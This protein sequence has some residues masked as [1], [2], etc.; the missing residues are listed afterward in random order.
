MPF[1]V[2]SLPERLIF[3]TTLR[4]MRVLYILLRRHL[5]IIAAECEVALS[6]LIQLL[7]PD[8]APPWKRVLCMEV[9]RGVYAEP[10]LIRKIF[11]SFDEQDG[12]KNILKDHV[13]ALVRLSTEKPAVIG[14]GQ[15]STI[16]RG[17][18]NP[19]GSSDEQAAMEA[20]G[21]VGMIGGAVSVQDANVPG[22][23][24]QWSSMRVPCIDHLDKTE[25]PSLPE[26]YIYS[27]ALTCINSFCEG[28][29]KFILPLTIP[30]DARS[31]KRHRGKTTVDQ[32]G[33]SSPTSE[34]RSTA[35]LDRRDSSSS[36]S[37]RKSQIPVNPL[38]LEQHALYAEIKS[39][40][41][42]I[43]TCWPAILASCS[44]FL[45]AAL[46]NDYYHGLV[47]SLQKFTHVAGLLRLSTPRDAFLTALGKAAVPSNVLSAATVAAS[48]STP[49]VENSGILANAKGLLSVDN[50]VSQSPTVAFDRNRQTPVE[51]N[52]SS[53]NMRNLLCLRA[54]LNLGIALGPTLENAWSIILETLQQ[55]DFIIH[56]SSRRT[57]RQNSGYG[58]G[59]EAPTVAESTSWHAGL[60]SEIRAV[61]TASARMFESTSDFPNEAFVDLVR[62]MCKLLGAGKPE[63]GDE[64]LTTTP[65]PG[66]LPTR[67]KPQPHRRF[68]SV[69]GISTS[70]ASRLGEDQ[71]VL[72]TLGDLA[73]VNLARLSNQEPD[74]SGWDILMANLIH[75]A[76]AT[77]ILTSIRLK[78]A[79]VLNRIAVET[80]TTTV[81]EP[82]D[83]RAAIQQRL[84]KALQAEVIPFGNGKMGDFGQSSAADIEVQRLA[85]EAMRS[86]LEQCGEALV[87]GWEMV[88]EIMASAFS[89][90]ASQSGNTDVDGRRP[91]SKSPKLV[92]SSFGS[93]QLI[94]SDFLSS[95]PTSCILILVDTLFKF[96][97]QDDDLNISL[98][99]ITFFW[100]VSDFLQG[101]SEAFSLTERASKAVE[102]GD[103][104]GLTHD[105]DV[106]DS[107]ASLWLLLLLRLTA[108]T[109]DHRAEVRNGAA[110]TLLRIFDAYG[111]RLSPESWRSCL[112]IVVFRMMEENRVHL[113][114]VN[115]SEDGG[116]EGVK[117]WT[118][119]TIVVLTG[120]AGFY[121]DYLDSFVQ[122]AAF[123]DSWQ[124]LVK[125]YEDLLLCGSLDVNAAIFSSFQR[126]LSK[127]KSAEKIGTS[128]LEL[129]WRLWS[130]GIPTGKES[131]ANNQDALSSYVACFQEV[132][133]LSKADA[134]FGEKR[135]V[136]ALDL[137]H[138]CVTQSDKP[139]YSNDVE[140]L[141]PLQVQV[142]DTFRSIRT[143][144]A[145]IPSAL[146][147]WLSSFVRLPIQSGSPSTD[148]G[149]L[150]FIALS[151]S[152]ME[153][154][155][156]VVLEHLE[157][158]LFASGA[159]DAVLGALAAPITVK[160][161]FSC[162]K[163]KPLWKAATS[164][165]LVILESAL[166][167]IQGSVKDERRLQQIWKRIVGVIVGVISAQTV[168]RPRDEIR[169][170]EDFDLAAFGRLRNLI[171]PTLGASVIADKTRRKYTE[172][173]F[174][175]SIV[176]S[177]APGE[178]P[179]SRSEILAGL[180]KVRRGRTY[181]PP[182][183]QR[184][185]MAYACLDELFALVQKHDGCGERVRL[186]QAASPFLILRAGITLRAYI[187][188]QPLRGRMP[189]PLTQ[190]RELLYVLS[191]LLSLASEPRA[192]PA[193]PG[194][195]S[196]S[197]K[198]LHRLYP[199]VGRAVRVAAVDGEVLEV[200]GRVL[201]EVG[202]EMG[203]TG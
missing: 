51:A 1:V 127:V 158:P 18:S 140:F 165:A 96:C 103:L 143:D 78:A 141:T 202:D 189:Q 4:I 185:R 84:L 186:A 122:Q 82:K 83:S 57:T 194:V 134:D 181:D 35:P 91:T 131:N 104:I 12:R 197:K 113:E 168:E 85:L 114:E 66:G 193:A 74:V 135:V 40:A 169:G 70:T 154:L 146:A 126:I 171:T 115:K 58:Q 3:P 94:C 23:S 86:I 102:E 182:P 180:Y 98:T 59:A 159:F 123:L 118:D 148:H 31:K 173:L 99:T 137:L 152:S 155:Q 20:G 145:G 54:L 203:V 100:N 28:L 55:A 19:K 172:C 176:H 21:V 149:Q 43:E 167:V 42:I 47:R 160:Y 76:S 15:Q 46:D 44:S 38:T 112:R 195:V 198:H 153:M 75:M 147:L 192:I 29:A 92:R 170:D 151:K 88:F 37:I 111:D 33:A 128:S 5:K 72:E 14:L 110:Q 190:R 119:T 56:A 49:A 183:V 166:P 61:E 41:A 71:F 11:S 87:S 107:H 191:R 108:V 36:R 97:C 50:L 163:G 17:Q 27:L 177:P 136:E 13:A 22:V 188:D 48:P 90:N 179:E 32:D 26:S 45:H 121:A 106:S 144:T 105:G 69:S 30:E 124:T 65:M 157:A 8:A 125:Y 162:G 161:G 130:K 16:P 95:L 196:E 187:A 73:K 63:S 116:V 68:P 133:R 7:D 120:V 64:S 2:K 53:L 142:L 132:Y 6:L 201:D 81:T 117:A 101:G 175:N 199:L 39:S 178:L 52:H 67:A 62:A 174:L 164:A 34:K 109:T 24:M 77:D 138:E 89:K 93:L 80:A 79:E 25:P 156:T 129:V 184:A 60:A 150:T 10:G 9:F 139:A 200:L